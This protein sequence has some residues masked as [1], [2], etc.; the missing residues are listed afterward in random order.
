[1]SCT[2]KEQPLLIPTVPAVACVWVV[3]YV[4]VVLETPGTSVEVMRV[5][6]AVVEVSVGHGPSQDLAETLFT[7]RAREK[8]KRPA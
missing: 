1:M 8:S 2:V 7:G 4:V 5:V 3:V 6:V